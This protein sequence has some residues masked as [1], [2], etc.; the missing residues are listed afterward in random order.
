MPFSRGT[1]YPVLSQRWSPKRISGLQLWLKADTG[2]WQDATMT[3]PA[4]A[5]GDVVGAWQDFSGQNNHATQGTTASKPLL[6]LNIVNGKP[7]VRFD[8]T[9]DSLAT[10][11]LTTGTVFAVFMH[12]A[13][14]PFGY[15]NLIS[16]PVDDNFILVQNADLAAFMTS[17]QVG[18]NIWINSVLTPSYTSGAYYIVC[19]KDTTPGTGVNVICGQAS[20]AAPLDGDVAEIL[21]YDSVLSSDAQKQVE[22]Y[23]NSR[24][25]IY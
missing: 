23:L 11:S 16:R 10:P 15:D 5:D 13:I 22:A 2:L 8:G 24:Y 1:R 6:K 21:I 18:S 25:A 12:L 3:T 4:V 19:G 7:V 20:T 9:D 14:A 17:F